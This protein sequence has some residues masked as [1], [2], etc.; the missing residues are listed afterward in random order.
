[1]DHKAL[2]LR[3]PVTPVPV[4]MVAVAIMMAMAMPTI[5]HPSAVIRSTDPAYILQARLCRDW[6]GRA[7]ATR[8]S[9][10]G[11]R[12]C[13]QRQRCRDQCKFERVHFFL[14]QLWPLPEEI[15]NAS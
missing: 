10:V 7:F 12:C 4:M 11:S 5:W 15:T 14:S 9:G 3:L 8:D 2:K 13:G 1:M 6:Q